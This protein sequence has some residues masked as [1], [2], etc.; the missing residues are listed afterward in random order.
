MILLNQNKMLNLHQ[1]QR[2]VETS[3]NL[4]RFRQTMRRI[5]SLTLSMLLQ[6]MNLSMHGRHYSK[7][8]DHPS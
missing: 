4:F 6:V 5:H 7:D 3:P 2:S 8:L 1:C